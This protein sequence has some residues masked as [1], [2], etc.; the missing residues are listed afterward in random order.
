MPIWP[1]QDSD[2]G[3]QRS[4]RLL[5]LLSDDATRETV[6]AT[7]LGMAR[8]LGAEVLLL[9]VMT[10]R[11]APLLG[12]APS[13]CDPA[14]ERC[15][16]YAA[17]AARRLLA[18][19]AAHAREQGIVCEEAAVWS[20]N[21]AACVVKVAQGHSSDLIVAASPK[22]RTLQRWLHGSIV[23]RLIDLASIPVLCVGGSAHADRAAA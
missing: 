16:E 7:G 6:V 14:G 4:P 23:H 2:P 11:V 8:A 3:A 18:T 21:P 13:L 22:L 15:R 19:V 5:I 12:E 9:H 1:I 20:D 10:Q 17:Q